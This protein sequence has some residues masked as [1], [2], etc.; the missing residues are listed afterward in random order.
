MAR[1]TARTKI[2]FKPRGVCSSTIT[3]LIRDG[4]IRSVRFRDGCNGNAKGI[5]RLVAGMRVEEVIRRLRGVDCEGKGTSCPDQ[6]ARALKAAQ[7][8]EAK[9]RRG[10]G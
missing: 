8:A 6:L 10:H 3:I 1:R 9:P 2:V 7:T 4:V 5:A